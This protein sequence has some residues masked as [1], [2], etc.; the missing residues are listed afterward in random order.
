METLTTPS[1]AFRTGKEKTGPNTSKSAKSGTMSKST[2]AKAGG[3][4]RPASRQ[5]SKDNA[6]ADRMALE[7]GTLL[8]SL[9]VMYA[10]VR[11]YHWNVKGP[12]FFALHQEFET[13]YTDL[14]LKTDELAE[15][16]LALGHSPEHRLSAY[17]DNVYVQESVMPET[18]AEMLA[19]LSSHLQRV[20]GLEKELLEYAGEHGD[21]STEDMLTGYVGEQ[22][23][24]QWML[25][26]Y[27]S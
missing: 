13:L 6:Y 21:I 16:I 9:Q 10:N 14:S 17:V 27:L 23:K 4:K 22:E 19:E 3:Q 18:A 7:L 12:Q 5:S 8:A 26:A 24:L 20:I 1:S 15:R 11:G 2:T 25:R